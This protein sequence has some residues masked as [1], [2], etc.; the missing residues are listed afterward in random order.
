MPD[1]VTPTSTAAA[2]STVQ[3][4]RIVISIQSANQLVRCGGILTSAF[5]KLKINKLFHIY[6]IFLGKEDMKKDSAVTKAM[7]SV[8]LSCKLNVT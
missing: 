3:G 2:S 4:E 7:I 5:K 8:A 6:F 1:I